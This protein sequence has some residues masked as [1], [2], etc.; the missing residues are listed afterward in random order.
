[1]WRDTTRDSSAYARVSNRGAIITLGPEKG[2]WGVS[3]YQNLEAEGCL[4]RAA[5]RRCVC[6]LPL[7]A[8]CG[9]RSNEYLGLPA[10]SLPLVLPTG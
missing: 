8:L 1:M 3:S 5:H 4:G 10:S 2:E 9:E 7:V 6:S